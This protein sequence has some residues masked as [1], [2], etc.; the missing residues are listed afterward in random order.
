MFTMLLKCIN[1]S[2]HS[3]DYGIF[4]IDSFDKMMVF[5]KEFFFSKKISYQEKAF[6]NILS[7]KGI[8]KTFYLKSLNK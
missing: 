1:Q 4:E 7:R 3:I 6:N 2:N 5:L 8:L